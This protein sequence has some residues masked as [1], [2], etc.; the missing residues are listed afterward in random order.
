[1][2]FKLDENLGTL[3]KELLESEGHDVTTIAAESLSGAT[4][5]RVYD[6]CC[7]EDRVLIT[8]DHDFGQVLRFPPESLAGIVVLECP[9]RLS[10]KAIDAR[11][12]ELATLLRSQPI[13]RELWIVEPGRIRIHQRK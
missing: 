11:I 9:G 8:L 13:N 10:P 3:G 4:D 7:A 6:V 2:K 5:V 1:M 12:A